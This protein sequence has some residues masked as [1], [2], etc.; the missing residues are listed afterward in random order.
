MTAFADCKSIEQESLEI[1][2][3]LFL[4]DLSDEGRFVIVSKGRLAKE[5]QENYGDVI[6]NKDDRIY[7]FELKAEL[8]YTGNLFLETWSNYDVNEGWMKKLRCDF[9][10]YHF[11]SNNRLY[12][13][14]FPELQRWSFD[15]KNIYRF[16]EKQQRKYEQLNITCGHIVPIQILKRELDHSKFKE[17]FLDE[18]YFSRQ[19]IHY[20]ARCANG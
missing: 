7:T 3:P 10:L 15:E 17:Y 4:F 16:R 5:I 9:L 2:K 18:E 1:L 8:N 12:F 11:L 20:K 19:T 14:D 6:S 13:I